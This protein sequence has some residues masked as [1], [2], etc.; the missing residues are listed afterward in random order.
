M[1]KKPDSEGGRSEAS[2]FAGGAGAAGVADGAGASLDFDGAGSGVRSDRGIGKIPGGVE[3]R[4]TI[5]AP[6]TRRAIRREVRS[7]SAGPA[8]SGPEPRRLRG[9][10]GAAAVGLAALAALTALGL[11]AP[12]VAAAAA[13]PQLRPEAPDRGAVGLGLALRKIASGVSVLSITAHPDDENNALHAALSRGDGARVS[14]LTLTRGGGGQNEIGPELFDGLRVLR[15]EELRTSHRL[16]GVEQYF[17]LVSDF[18]YSFSV[19]ETLE[20]WGRER[21]L[22]EVVRM[23]RMLR[24]DVVLTLPPAGAGGGQHHQATG[25]LAH[26]A[27]DAAGDPSRFPGHLAEGLPP[28][29]PLKLFVS[30]VGGGPVSGP[31]SEA[32]IVR[33]ETE[34]WDPLLG[35]TYADLGQ[36][37]RAAHRCQGMGQ[38]R[39][40][41]FGR[42][43]VLLEARNEI[44][45]DGP[46]GADDGLFAGIPTGLDRYRAFL[47]GDAAAPARMGLGA[48]GGAVA[49]AQ[50]AFSAG[51]PD[52]SIGALGQALR[53]VRDLR[54][55]ARRLPEADAYELEHRLAPK[56]DLIEQALALAHGLEAHPVASASE[57]VPGGRFQTEVAVRVGGPEALSVDVG[58]E[59]P[60]GWRIEPAGE[61]AAPARGPGR[62]RGPAG[63]PV[64]RAD[65]LPQFV[66]PRGALRTRFTVTAAPDADFSRPAFRAGPDEDRFLMAEGVS[67]GAAVPPP[68]VQARIDFSSG[69]V[70]ASIRVPVEYRYEGPWVGAE[71]QKEVS[72]LP[73]ASVLVAPE[74]VVFP[75]GGREREL[76]V[77]LTHR[78]SGAAEYEVRLAAPP[79]WT[80]APEAGAAAFAGPGE[81]RVEFT[82]SA[83]AGVPEGAHALSAEARLTGGENPGRQAVFA[84]TVETVAYH[85]IE[86]RHLFRPAEANALVVDAAVAPVR[87]GYVEGVGDEVAEAIAQ[88]GVPLTDLDEA[89]LAE[90]DLSAFDTIVLG[91]RAY[92]ARPDLRAHN[93]RLIEFVERGGTLLVQY[94]K[95]EFNAAAWGPYP[96]S[97]GRGRVTVEDAP[98]RALVPEHPV[99]RTPN[100][101]GDS[102]WAGWVQERGL[103]FLAP[104]GDPAYADLLASEDPWEYNAGEKRGILVEARRGEGRWLY[105]GLGLWRQLPAGTPG[106]Y[107]LLANLLS[108]GAGPAPITDGR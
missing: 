78:G 94:N 17:G 64:T 71:K 15:T 77:A 38:V 84:E 95:F 6:V 79:G 14:L 33:R 22:G 40:S 10:S 66:A 67:F 80:V 29:Q 98:M 65:D 103:Y 56:E 28:W 68:P 60:P 25:L 54:G 42:P 36:E 52:R 97:V 18:G 12:P 30:G 34:V 4:G 27:F 92:L 48:L 20:K 82:V 89:A 93:H 53:A 47:T 91:V 57:V 44:S 85:H 7:E 106:A 74:I 76:S 107:R 11:L 43:A 83:P 19:E 102:D 23:I 99:F 73:L 39:T 1:R 35:R 50:A 16:D 70:A 59:A 45:P 62:R 69:G 51:A 41:V 58:L 101:I 31:D 32:R 24:P 37:A 87:V 90:G 96:V 55:E 105:L 86:T 108:L 3:V 21:T 13:A 9:T 49:A 81:T 72:V 5:P 2:V 26:E 61:D 8:D 100:R 88:L 46:P 104:G 63:P 75:R